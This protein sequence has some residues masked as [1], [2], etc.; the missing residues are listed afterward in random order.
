[1]IKTRI[2]LEWLAWK[3]NIQQISKHYYGCYPA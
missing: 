3:N 2:N 1:M